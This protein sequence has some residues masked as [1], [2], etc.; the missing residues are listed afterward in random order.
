M[1]RSQVRLLGLTAGL[2]VFLVAAA[3]VYMI[4]MARLE[5]AP[6]T[7]WQAFEWASETLSTTGYGSD[8]RWSHPLMILL[9]ISVQM[10]GIILVPLIISIYLLPFLAER[11]EQKVPREA[12]RTLA[13]HVIVYG[14][15]PAV[16]ILLQRLSAKG[17]RT[18]VAE[19]DEE[20]AREVLEQ[21]QAVVFRRSDEEILEACNLKTAR[22]LVAN[23]RD[24][25]NAGV[26]LRARQLGFR[27]EIYA[28][29]SE[30]AHRM[31]MQ[32]AG[33]TAAY[34][35]RHIIA[36]ALAAYASDSISP[37]LPGVE[38]LDPVER[39]EIRIGPRSRVAGLTLRE[40]EI[41]HA[42]GA[43]VVGI[44]N[45]SHLVTRCNGD[46]K[47][48]PGSILEVVG[49][50]GA[51]EAAA[52]FTGG[53][54]LRREGPLLIAG[55]GEVGRKVH[56]LLTDAGEEVRVIER[57]PS[58][59]VDVVGNVLDASVLERA[60]IRQARGVIL[61]LDTDDA[62]LFATVIVRDLVADVAVIA[63][64]NH[65]RNLE[66]IHRA[67]ADFALSISDISGEML[68]AR[69]LGQGERARDEHRRVVA[70]SAGDFA[71]RTI[72]ELGL[73]AQGAS[74]LAIGRAGSVITRVGPDLRIE[75]EDSLWICGA[76]EAV[77]ALTARPRGLAATTP[78]AV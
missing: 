26:I 17:L 32:L 27:G 75:P 37:R 24:E 49:D 48:E 76:K 60:E 29:V 74:I 68:S 33:A 42:T 13:D 30:P 39:R 73:R 5:G 22:A 23:G 71:G 20:R 55:F 16:E 31:P 45:R 53:M 2:L 50:R 36:A 6:R 28:F 47:I 43:V 69:M 18:L 25:E 19:T 65:A 72:A 63:R 11:F 52:R 12:D 7:F 57:Q 54:F 4:G 21:R 40:A 78:A 8:N 56:E 46:T 66:N 14:F 41:G 15:G 64:V 35:P 44:W 9:V 38:G 62:T 58:D 77:S 67:G 1:V 51:L 61:A 70:V 3:L 34:T 10:V 59:K